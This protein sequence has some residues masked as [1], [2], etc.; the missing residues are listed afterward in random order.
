[1]EAK[2]QEA[3]VPINQGQI[4]YLKLELFS[5]AYEDTQDFGTESKILIDGNN[6]RFVKYN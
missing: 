2:Q 1:M 3:V 4:E 5:W 6:V